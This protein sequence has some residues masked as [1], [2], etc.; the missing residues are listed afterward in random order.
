MDS[1]Q[2]KIENFSRTGPGKR[3]HTGS[4]GCWGHDS[5]AWGRGR[6]VPRAV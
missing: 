3:L 1:E 2:D 5:V 6:H 4:R